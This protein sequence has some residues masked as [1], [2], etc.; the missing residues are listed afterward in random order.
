MARKQ[1]TRQESATA[2]TEKVQA[3]LAVLGTAVSGLRSGEDWTRYL[4]FQ[5]KLYN[6]S[7]NNVMLLVAQHIALFEAG[8]V[9]TP[10]P[11]YVASYRKW[12]ELGRQV[13]K[14]QTG[15]AV[16]APMRGTRREATGPDGN[17][18]RVLGKDEHPE[19]G[20]QEVRTSFMRG[21]TVEK[22][23]SAEQTTG[24]PLPE[25]PSPQLLEGE[26]PPGLGVAVAALIESKGFTVAT[27][28]SASFIRGA[29]GLTDWRQ[30]T[31]QVRDDMDDASMVRTLIH[32]AAHVL[33]HDGS[34]PA[35][36]P[37][38]L[39]EVEAESVAFVAS[40]VHGMG[41]GEYSFPYIAGWAGTEDPQKVIT[42]TAQRVAQA[43]QT[44]IE[45]SPAEY[46]HGGKAALTFTPSPTVTADSPTVTPEPMKI[47][48]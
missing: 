2:R 27:V 6:Y 44:I 14:G 37:R 20:E 24:E 32:E 21:F 26:A 19:P 36:M 23:F 28:A 3:A 45:L 41:T 38:G 8:K 25:R 47:G 9:A 7:A 46:T 39:K 5:S 48:A 18:I 1:P 42:K 34:R 35:T 30:R 29:N 16:I 13:A 33:L 11:S 4:G 43:S 40:R 17:V 22:V 15:L 10:I 12:L 31:V